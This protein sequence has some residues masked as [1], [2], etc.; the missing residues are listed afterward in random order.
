VKARAAAAV[1]QEGEE[2]AAAGAVVQKEEEEEEE[3]GAA[4]QKEE[5]EEAPGVR[6]RVVARRRKGKRLS[7][8]LTHLRAEILGAGQTYSLTSRTYNSSPTSRQRLQEQRDRQARPLPVIRRARLRQ[9]QASSQTA[10]MAPL[11]S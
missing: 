2:E 5:E 6:R 7:C 4:V 11:G 8:A 9:H 1:A 3:A 10:H